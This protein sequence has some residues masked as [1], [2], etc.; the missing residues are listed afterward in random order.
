MKILLIHP[1]IQVG[2]GELVII[3]LANYFVKRGH[4]VGIVC[5]FVDTQFTEK[6]DKRIIFYTPH[7]VLS[8]LT[9]LH[10]GLLIIC[11][12]PYLLF[13]TVFLAKKYDVLFPHNFPSIFFASVA[14]LFF[15]TPLVWEYNEGAPLPKFLSFLED[16][17][18]KTSDAVIVLDNKNKIVVKK[19]FGKIATVL[20]PGVDF[21]FWSHLTS[22]D[23]SFAKKTILLSVG[24]LH[25][26]KNQILL[27]DVAAQLLSKI[28]SLHVILVGK[29]PDHGRIIKKIIDL[30]MT[31]HI[32]LTGSISND[33]LRRLYKSAFVVCFPARDQTW[34]LTPFE[35]LCQKTVSIVSD[36][37]GAGEVLGPN[38]IALI[39]KPTVADFTCTILKAYKQKE[40]L[41][42]IGKKGYTFVKENL[43]WENFSKQVEEIVRDTVLKKQLEGIG[44][45]E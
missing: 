18:G 36:E 16:I 14:K 8:S 22:A 32:T 41:A 40:L 26:Q 5:C 33:N 44:I 15:K 28:P 13:A 37:A 43:T 12:F 3:R 34:G 20:R 23:A 4:T 19:R 17:S 42:R 2:G 7:S 35:A 25:P 11:G 24:K 10:K 29:G 1:F 39:A 30:K 6:I 21:S 9:R 38:R 27:I 31:K 45:K